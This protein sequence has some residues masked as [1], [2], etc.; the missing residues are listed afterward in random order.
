MYYIG[1]GGTNLK[2]MDKHLKTKA[3]N[4]LLLFNSKIVNDEELKKVKRGTLSQQK[5]IDSKS[6]LNQSEMSKSTAATVQV[7]T[8]VVGKR[9]SETNTG[10]LSST[11]LLSYGE[12]NP[13]L[14][15]FQ[16]KSRRIE[17]ADESDHKLLKL[18]AP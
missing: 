14:K 9:M 8:P 4:S 13:L 11:R 16:S 15:S 5:K 12:N 2:R 1:E 3:G 18:K 10:F 7:Q 17:C 6:T